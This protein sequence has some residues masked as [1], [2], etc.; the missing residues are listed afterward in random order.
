[1]TQVEVRGLTKRFGRTTL[2]EATSFHP[3]RRARDHLRVLAA[4][5]TRLNRDV[6]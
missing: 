4:V 1:M 5:L 6:T 2:L 3:G